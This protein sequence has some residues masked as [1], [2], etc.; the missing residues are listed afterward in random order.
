MNKISKY[1][2][3]KKYNNDTLLYNAKNGKILISE[4]T[5]QLN[6]HFIDSF[7]IDSEEDEYESV[8]KRHKAYLLKKRDYIRF[9]IFPT[10]DCNA[11]C[12]YCYEHYMKKQTMND[13]TIQSTIDYIIN[14]S[15]PYKKIRIYWFGGEPLVAERTIDI[16]TTS[17]I[18]YCEKEGKS[19]K[20]SIATNASLISTP[21]LKKMIDKWKIDKIEFAFDGAHD[22]HN[23]SKDYNI[24][25]FDAFNHNINL[26]P[27]IIESGIS[28][29]IRLNCNNRNIEELMNLAET[30]LYKYGKNNNFNLYVGIISNK[31]SMIDN[32]YFIKPHDYGNIMIRY[33]EQLHKTDCFSLSK[34]PLKPKVTNCYSS[35][36]NA[37]V[38]SSSGLVTKCQACPDI[39]L[40]A[41]DNVNSTNNKFVNNGKKWS[42][43]YI[44]K[45]KECKIFPICL[46]GCLSDKLC[47]GI[48]PCRTEYYYMDQLLSYVYKYMKSNNI[49]SYDWTNDTMI[50]KTDF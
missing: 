23:S 36:P 47:F 29:S 48:S 3:K 37:L 33:F 2:F 22:R 21:L 44:D 34:T 41:I 38:I 45:C 50:K 20:A 19:Y 17:I 8:A 13:L 7:F 5:E 39:A 10:M 9:T 46:G 31:T 49:I 35:N 27:R 25:G 4:T 40:L 30:L 11:N 1:T 16:I 18:S 43:H 42:N 28:L 12:S 26:I 32:D 24:K 15:K 14:L 6:S